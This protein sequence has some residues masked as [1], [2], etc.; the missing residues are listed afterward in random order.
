MFIKIYSVIHAYI[1]MYMICNWM[2][3]F[4]M[5]TT[6]AIVFES[7][8]ETLLGIGIYMYIIYCNI[9]VIEYYIQRYLYHSICMLVIYV[10]VICNMHIIVMN[11][12]I[13]R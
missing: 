1:F 5:S 12:Y 7:I 9:Y 10:L 6:Q 3:G 11:I 2:L 13:Y 4:F 8:L